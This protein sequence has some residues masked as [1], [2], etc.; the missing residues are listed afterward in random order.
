MGQGQKND[1]Q[2]DRRKKQTVCDR[3]SVAYRSKQGNCIDSFH[4]NRLHKPI[5]LWRIPQSPQKS[6]K[7]LML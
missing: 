2:T 1:I 3:K 5:T 7:G 6:K 4:P